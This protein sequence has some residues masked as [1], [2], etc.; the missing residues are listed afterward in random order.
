MAKGQTH[1]D[2]IFGTSYGGGDDDDDDDN[3]DD[4]D[5]AMRESLRTAT[6]DE[7]KR[8]MYSRRQSVRE[9]GGS[10]GSKSGGGLF[11]RFRN[12]FSTSGRKQTKR[13]TPTSSIN[14]EEEETQF[15]VPQT[16]I[17]DEQ[18]QVHLTF[19]CLLM[20]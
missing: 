8:K 12:V 3:E 17:S 6:E 1:T 5:I 19:K 14:L 2:R 7:H 10:S 4:M 15:T 18:L 16:M 13:S 20:Q 11:G 9:A